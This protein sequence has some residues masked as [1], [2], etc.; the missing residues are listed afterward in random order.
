ML[1]DY[2]AIVFFAA[3]AFFIPAAFLLASRL[4]RPSSAGNRV[5][6]SPYESGEKTIGS[7][8]DL[9]IEYFPF[10][11]LFL[12]F[13]VVAVI[14]LLW[15]PSAR[16]TGLTNGLLVIGMLVLAAALATLGYMLAGDKRAK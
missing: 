14:V 16:V 6:D 1:Y 15:S 5:K 13:E 8:R 11:M 3:F 10:F 7:S 9:D 2:I 12:P 4:L